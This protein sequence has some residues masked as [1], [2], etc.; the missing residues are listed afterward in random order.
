MA[1]RVSGPLSHS[2]RSALDPGASPG[3]SERHPETNASTATRADAPDRAVETDSEQVGVLLRWTLLLALVAAGLALVPLWVPLLLAAW[4]AVAVQPLHL[5]MIQRFGG[6][7]RAAGVMTVLLV[8]LALAPLVTLGLSL[9]NTIIDLVQ[10]LQKSGDFRK[11]FQ[12]LVATESDLSLQEL[13][14]Q[15]IIEV[16]RRHGGGALT[17]ANTLFGAATA[18]VIGIVVFLFGFYTFLVHGNRTY[19]WLLDHSPLPRRH[20][21]RL[22]AAFVETGKGLLISIGLTALL[23]GVVATLG[24][25]VIG[26]PQPLVLGLLTTFAAFIPSIGTGLVWVPVTIG[27]FIADRTAA[28]IAV[29]VLGAVVS[30]VDNFVR[31]WL[32]RYGNLQLPMFVIFIAMLGGIAAFGAWGLL[33][34]PLFVRLAVEVLSLWREEQATEIE[35][36]T[37]S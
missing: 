22:A 34:G 35:A 11:G 4:C 3:A 1:T 16:F 21:K 23:Q 7:G 31:P 9:A 10:Q 15:R 28:S 13:T 20:M 24:Y 33:V 30:V 14:P 6:S 27:L 29:L 5:R 32:S 12:A 36:F 8:V 25:L 18:L 37:K 2:G 17:A 26:V 19:R